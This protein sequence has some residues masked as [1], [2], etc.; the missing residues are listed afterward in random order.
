MSGQDLLLIVNIVS[1]SMAGV[2][3]LLWALTWAHRRAVMP[4][5][6]NLVVSLAAFG[7]A[8]AYSFIAAGWVIDTSTTLRPVLPLV[9]LGP[10]LARWYELQVEHR[11][12]AYAAALA[13]ELA[14]R[15]G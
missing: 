12:E 9:L 6:L 8:V 3:Y 4:T 2:T 11:R 10:T 5:I 15:S 13:D 1:A 7:F 14:K